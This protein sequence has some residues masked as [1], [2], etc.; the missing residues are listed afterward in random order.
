MPGYVP[1]ALQLF[2]VGLYF[3]LLFSHAYL[4]RI[5]SFFS[6]SQGREKGFHH[7][8]ANG[9]CERRGEVDRKKR[10]DMGSKLTPEAK[11]SFRLKLKRAKINPKSPPVPPPPTT[12]VAEDAAAETNHGEEMVTEQHEI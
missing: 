7:V 4:L 12:S 8:L 2:F 3:S 5:V 10:S 9:V 6:L 1:V 11:E